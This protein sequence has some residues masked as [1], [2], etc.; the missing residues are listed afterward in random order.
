ME[1]PT[2][3]TAEV[4]ARHVEGDGGLE[5]KITDISQMGNMTGKAGGGSPLLC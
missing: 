1:Q 3:G 4:Q 2:W 5:A